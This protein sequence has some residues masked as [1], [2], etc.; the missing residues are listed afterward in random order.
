MI[1]RHIT[2]FRLSLMAADAIS[3]MAV[4][5]AVSIVRWP[6]IDWR[7]SW[8]RAGIEPFGVVGAFAAAWMTVLWLLGMY[9]LRARWTVRSEALDVLRAGTLVAVVTFAALYVLKL[10]QVSRLFLI[11]LF[12]A[13]VAVTFGS[14]LAL[15]AVFAAARDRGLNTRFV[16]MVGTDRVAQEFA[17]RIERH[18]DLG[19]RAI[20]HLALGPA[21]SVSGHG[22]SGAAAANAVDPADAAPFQLSRPILGR[23]DEIEDVLHAKVVDEV[24][25]CLPSS[26]WGLVEAITTICEGEGKI[27]RIPLTDGALSLPGARREEF[28]GI[29]ILSLVYGPDRTIGLLGK[30]LLDMTLGGAALVVLSPLFLAV[31]AIVRTLDGRPVLFRQTR[32]GLHGREFQVV[33]FRTMV[34]DAEERLSELLDLNEIAG[35]AFKL[36]ADPRLTRTGRWLRRTSIDELPQ[37]WNVFR[38]EMSIV[39]PRPPLPR[40]VAGYDVWHRRRLSMKP[41]ITGLWQVSARHEEAFDRWVELDLDYIDRWSLWLD[42]KIMLRTIP[43]MLQGR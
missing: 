38:G 35:H 11:E 37:F 25:I 23:L 30:R 43:A 27:V 3:A 9:R 22:T 6:G 29:P 31:A 41:G 2:A 14:R 21:A 42:L 39:G 33:K 40:E 26:A 19:L 15:R 24:V 8:L 34:P 17:D 4:F 7:D 1:R 32:V 20:G 13:Q 36:S 12:P 16:L 10:P 18:R 28:D 5:V